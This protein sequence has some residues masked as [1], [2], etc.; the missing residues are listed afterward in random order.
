MDSSSILF[1]NCLLYVLLFLRNMRKK[2]GVF[3]LLLTAVY[4]ATSVGCVYFYSRGEYLSRNLLLWPFLYYFMIFVLLIQPFQKRINIKKTVTIS[5]YS[6]LNKLFSGY[7]FVSILYIFILS[8]SVIYAIRSGNWLSIYLR[9][10]GSD[11]VF[12]HNLFERLIIN[13]TSYFKIPALFYAFY[14]YSKGIPF[15][16]KRLLMIMPFITTFFWALF[17]ASRTDLLVIATLYFVCFLIF[18]NELSSTFKKRALIFSSVMGWLAMMFILAVNVSR[19]GTGGQSWLSM[20]FGESFI[21]A[22]N[23]IGYTYRLG[24]G[25]YF[26]NQFYHIF[27]IPITPYLCSIDDGT[28]FHTLIGMRY[29]DFGMLGTIIYAIIASLLLKLILRKRYLG[30]GDIYLIVYYFITVFIGVF[31]D[32]A[33]AYS[34]SIVIVI[35]I[36]LNYISL[37]NVRA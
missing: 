33:N 29:S 6:L 2:R 27:G 12:Y 23:T 13:F 11:A 26:F 36:M 5:N 17:T 24:E 4:V 34:W 14:V 19:F 25:S 28:A 10:R 31:Y 15:K 22:H 30:L 7:V 20:Y 1:L 9:M 35:S 18:T 21:V 37:K 3:S 32:A 8:G 16:R